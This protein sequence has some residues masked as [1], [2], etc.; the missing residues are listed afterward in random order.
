MPIILL[1]QTL[2]IHKNDGTI[3][4]ITI[5]EIDSITFSTTN[6][7]EIGIPC[8]GIPTVTYEGQTYNTLQIGDQCWLKENLN[9][10]TM[11]ESNVGGFLQTDN[12]IIEKYCYNNIETN[13]TKYGG[14]YE[15]TEAMQYVTTERAQGICPNGWH[16][17]TQGEYETLASYVNYEAAK[18]VDE[19]QTT[20]GYAATN[21][22]GFSALFAGGR[23]YYNGLFIN[24]GGTTYFWSSAES[25]SGSAYYLRLGSDSS[26]VSLDYVYKD[27]GFSVRCLKD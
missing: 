6:G 5:S 25:S 9:I 14:L 22:T 11:I 18:L 23:Y 4:N 19:S 12:G 3:E 24:L 20:S 8:P 15:W 21:E 1:S 10:G 27:F 13:C 26:N 17:P 2:Q 16:I 7:G